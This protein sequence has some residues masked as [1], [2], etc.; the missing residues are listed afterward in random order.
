MTQ[1]NHPEPGGEM[2]IC[3]R[4]LTGLLGYLLF[5]AAWFALA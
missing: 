1:S 4:I 2:P 5:A 3:R